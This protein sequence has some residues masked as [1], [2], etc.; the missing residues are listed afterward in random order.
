MVDRV[1]KAV[2]YCGGACT[3]NELKY[4]YNVV[5]KTDYSKDTQPLYGAGRND[6]FTHPLLKKCVIPKKNGSFK[7]I[8]GLY[9]E[10]AA[11]V[12]RLSGFNTDDTKKTLEEVGNLSV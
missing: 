7:L 3:L 9:E 12:D 1:L 11:L 8:Y 6:V 5:N 10:V 4:C 2:V